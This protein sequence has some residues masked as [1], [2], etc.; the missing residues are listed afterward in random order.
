ME[1]NIHYTSNLK[2]LYAMSKWVTNA[3]FSSRPCYEHILVFHQ[4]PLPQRCQQSKKIIIK[5][6]NPI[7]KMDWKFTIL[8]NPGLKFQSEMVLFNY[9]SLIINRESQNFF[10]LTFG[11]NSKKW[12]I[13]IAHK[14]IFFRARASA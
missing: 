11:F 2:K 12:T 8:F 14:H 4:L 13:Y 9:K 1:Q 7:K 10:R 6:L 3:T 5:I